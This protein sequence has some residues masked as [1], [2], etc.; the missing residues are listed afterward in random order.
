MTRRV[1]EPA[2]LRF[3]DVVTSSHSHT[4]HLDPVTLRALRPRALVC[5]SGARALAA[6]RAC[7]VAQGVE[8]DET[9]EVGGFRLTAVRAEHDS[10]GGAVGF[11]IEAGPWTLYHSG[12]TTAYGGLAE[13][14]RPFALDIA[15]LPINGKLEN[16][17]GREAARVAKGARAALA[18][19]CHFEMFEF[20]TASPD[21][22]VEECAR[23]G[24]PYRVLRAGE[25]LTLAA[26]DAGR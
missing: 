18:V 6:E 4:D 21:D 12:D 13:R 26:Q 3:V 8:V 5:P 23:L 25:R 9:A 16:M 10:P 22:F 24:Q 19:P 15:L 17:N 2:R 11:V 1:V 14:L 7:V 20:N